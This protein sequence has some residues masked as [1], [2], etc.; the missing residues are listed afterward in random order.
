[1]NYIDLLRPLAFVRCSHSVG[2]ITSLPRKNKQSRLTNVL[3]TV[4]LLAFVMVMG[5]SS[6]LGETR[7][8]TFGAPAG[9][10]SWNSATNTYSWT[11]NYSNLMPIFSF[12]NGELANY[13]S[14]HLTTSDYT[15]QYRVCF[16][17][18]TDPKATITF[19][20]AGQK[21]LVLAER[22]E[23]KDLNLSEI[24]SIQFGG[25]STSG[26]IGIDPSSV[27][28]EGPTVYTVTFGP[29]T[30][31]W[32]TVTAKRID[33][34]AEITSG[35]QVPSGTN[36]TFTATPASSD[37]LTWGWEGASTAYSNS[38]TVTVNS[39]ISITHNFTP[40]IVLPQK[41]LNKNQ[42]K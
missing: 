40:G 24:T 13:T 31:G 33:T 23:T 8:A 14:L 38:T 35:S 3:K 9:N 20:S 37:Y 5:G 15:S 30:A 27:Y 16:M 7:S 12:S 10:G 41:R 6:A 18:G 21:D 34:N 19:Y 17:K 39:D 28:L 2:D 42:P 32:G 4:F 11:L 25:A 29:N 1:M 22:S 36:V 26:S